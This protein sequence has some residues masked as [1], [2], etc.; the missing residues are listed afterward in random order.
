V[1]FTFIFSEHTLT[2]TNT[3]QGEMPPTGKQIKIWGISI[4]HFAN[5]KLTRESIA[6][7]NQALMD[8][9]GYTMMPA[10]NTQ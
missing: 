8:Q 4:V 10:S 5:G 6:F 7:D 1:S 9:L 3:G 2:G